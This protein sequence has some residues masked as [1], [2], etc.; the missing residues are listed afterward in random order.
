MKSLQQ[1]IIVASILI[2]SASFTYGQVSKHGRGADGQ[3]YRI[4]EN[5]YKLI[6]QLAELEVTIDEQNREILSL[7]NEIA[8]KDVKLKGCTKGSERKISESDMTGD[9]A[10][11]GKDSQCLKLECNCEDRL[12]PQ[13]QCPPCKSPG[14]DCPEVGCPEADCLSVA[15]PLKDKILLLE[16]TVNNL[17]RNNKALEEKLS[18]TEKD[19]GDTLATQGRTVVS[20][21]EKYSK[22]ITQQASE[23]ENRLSI[24]EA[25]LAK[26]QEQ[27]SNKDVKEREL[28]A[29]IE[30]LN[31]RIQAQDGVISLYEKQLA[32]SAKSEPKLTALQ[33]A[34]KVEARSTVSAI[35]RAIPRE[36][37]ERLASIQ[38][39]INDRKSLY[40]R[41]KDSR[42]Q[43]SITLQELRTRNGES[44]D[45]LRNSAS[46]LTTPDQVDELLEKL[47]EIE[48]ILND[49]L[50]VLRRIT[51]I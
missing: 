1:T 43:I 10:I 33:T 38:K 9:W 51:K 32:S 5:G 2:L 27:I 12:P 11:K 44:L 18:L 8:E 35:P 50:K 31:Q 48:K 19:Y 23:Y 34:P 7:E 37:N 39:L 16:S 47:S 40:D 22:Q 41:Q 13:V 42:T 3:A 49:D 28:L 17:Q 4:D 29:K 30:V 45:N 20:K 26:A 24:N 36:I 14:S 25:E 6:D 46:V 15:S 21:E